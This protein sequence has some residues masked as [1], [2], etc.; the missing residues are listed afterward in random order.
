[1]YWDW[2]RGAILAGII[3]LTFFTLYVTFSPEKC[4]NLECF[5]ENLAKCMPATYVNE[6][7]EASWGYQIAG[8]KDDKCRIEVTLLSA[9][10]GPLG[11][12]DYEG[13]SMVCAYQLGYLTFPEKNLDACSGELKEN[14]Q[15]VI[16]E[17][18]YRYIIDNLGE[19]S[20]GVDEI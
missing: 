12:R 20:E 8:R 10:E 16:I 17:K 15:S 19:I 1:M 11:L 7:P 14:M 13:N 3:I 6:E 4:P 18:L 9:K 2:K 5:Q